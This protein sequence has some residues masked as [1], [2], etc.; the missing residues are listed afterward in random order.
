MKFK[1]RIDLPNAQYHLDVERFFM[2][3]SIEKFR[4]TIKDK[5]FILQSDRPLLLSTGA[6]KSVKW[7]LL[8]MPKVDPSSVENV[9]YAIFRMQEAIEAHL[10]KVEPTLQAYL[11]NRTVETSQSTGAS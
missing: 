5:A 3:E 6:H 2:G 9:T 11:A 4:T 7:K 1:I 10:T 8:E